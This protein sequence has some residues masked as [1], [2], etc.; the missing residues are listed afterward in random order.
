MKR[1]IAIIALAATAISLSLPAQAQTLKTVRDRGTLICGVNPDLIGFSKPD[2]KGGW[3]G[4]DVDFCKALA[5]AIF[6]DPTKVQFVALGTT[7]RFTA[8]QSKEIDVLSRNSTWTMAREAGLGLSFPATT[9]YDGQGFIVP[10]ASG[11]NSALELN[12]ASACVQTDTTNQLNLTDYFNAN[13]IEHQVQTFTSLDDALKAYDAGRCKTFS[14]DT[15]QL[16]AL[17][18]R[19]AKPAEHVILPEVIS[20]EPLGPA[21][22][23]D[24]MQWFNIVRWT[25]F[26]MINAEELGVS[27]QTIDEAL[28][29][30]KPDVKR[31]VGADEGFGEKLGL[32]KDWAVRIV[33]LVGNYG[34]VFERNVGG[35]SELK[36]ARGLN[37]LWTR[38]GIQY[39]PPVR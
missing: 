28:R 3:A 16:H 34:E 23:G 7:N 1:H 38:G 26:A 19:L 33:K 4:F 30:E 27:S 21:V 35:K 15:S 25:H 20:K 24:D 13:K 37:D 31:L 18:L 5:A 29:S 39:A 36:I 17:R 10:R 6:N 12:G 8:L 14:A 11:A 9:Y 22:R 32:T 2:G